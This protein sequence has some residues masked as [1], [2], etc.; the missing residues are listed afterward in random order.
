MKKLVLFSLL[1]IISLVVITGCVTNKKSNSS[2][3]NSLKEYN[4]D[5]VSFKLDG[6]DS[7]SGMKYNISKDFD[8]RN[9]ASTTTYTLY[10]DKNK[11]KY[12]VANIVFSLSITADIMQ[13]ESN[14]ESD[15]NKLNNNIS[16]KNITRDKKNIN[17][18]T[19]E[20]ISLDNYYDTGSD[21]HFKNHSYY[22]ESYD[23]KYYTTYIVSF[24]KVDNTEEF[25]NE[26]LSSI[27][28]N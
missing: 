13:T 1:I 24:N 20:F 26:F 23:G 5:G 4:I 7:T 8:K 17:G 9:G 19:W 11:D 10:K 14:I 16:L 22:Y 3:D 25:E 2:S 15:I 28:F 21:N 18:I 6:E 27:V 12:D